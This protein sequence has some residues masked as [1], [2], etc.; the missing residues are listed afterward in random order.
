MTSNIVIRTL[1][2]EVVDLEALVSALGSRNDRC[3]AD[4]RVVDTRVGDQVSLELVEID[5]QGTVEA[6]GG[7]DGADDL[8]NE[9]VKV[10]IR[11][12]RNAEVAT[13]DIVDSL[14]VDEE[15]A[16]RVLNGAVSGENGVVRLDDG[17][18]DGGSRVDGEFQLRLLTV[19]G[20]KA[21]QHQGTETRTSTATKGV[22][23]K[24]T[25][26]GLAVVYIDPHISYQTTA[27]EYTR[28]QNSPAT[29]RTRSMTRSIISFP[30]V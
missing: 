29:R 19:L 27:R 25:L 30:I 21:L 28:G 13:A 22:E 16:V 24:E 8:S 12:T 14:I 4:K 2:G 3:V 7:G 11:R 23:Y 20:S 6:E 18:G 9:T 17:G 5:V 15:S 26:E 10:A 1:E